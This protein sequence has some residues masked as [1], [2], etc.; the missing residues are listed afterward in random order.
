MAAS[1]TAGIA[2]TRTSPHRITSQAII[3]P[4]RGW[5]SASQDSVMPPMN[6][7]TTL[8]TKVTAASRADWV[9]LNTSTVSATRAN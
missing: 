9:R 5:R 4:R 6:V 2:M 3:T 8:T 1:G 7:G